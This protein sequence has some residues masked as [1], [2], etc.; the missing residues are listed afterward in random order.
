[1]LIRKQHNKLTDFIETNFTGNLDRDEGAR[2]FFIT[3]AAKETILE[4]S[5]GKKLRVL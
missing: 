4:I 5:Q 3:E 1:M 2:I